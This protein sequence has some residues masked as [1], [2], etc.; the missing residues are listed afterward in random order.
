MKG[1]GFVCSGRLARGGRK[2]ISS[3]NYR[4]RFLSAALCI[5]AFSTG[6]ALSQATPETASQSASDPKVTDKANAYY[7]FAMGHLYAELAGAFGNRS[8]YTNKAIEYYRQAMKLDPSASFLSQELTDL[9]IQAGRI[10]D[11]V[12][13]AE[14]L[15]KQDPDNLD[16]RRLL[17]QIYARLIGDPDQHKVNDEMLQRA[18]EQFQKVTEK[19]PSDIDS[20]L[21]LGR[22]ERVGGNSVEAE[23]DFKKVLDRDP[24]NEEALTELARVYAGVGDN[25][26]A[27]EMLRLVTSKHPSPRTLAELASF[28]HN[29]HDYANAADVWR[30][31]LQMD[32]DNTRL[33]HALADDLLSADRTADA[34][35]LYQDLAAADPRDPQ[36][37][38]RLAEIYRERG[39]FAKAHAALGKARELDPQNLEVRY[40]EVNLLEKE[41]KPDAAIAALRAMLDDTAS[42]NYTEDEKA[43]RTI[44]LERLGMLY[45]DSQHYNEAVEAFRQMAELDPEAAPRASAAIIDTWRTAK[46]L[47]KADAEV[48]AALKKFPKDR[49][50]T[51][52]KAWLLADAGKIDDAVATLRTLLDG[53]KEWGTQITIAQVYE[54]GKRWEDMGKALE[55]AEKVADSSQEK[56]TVA[57]MRGAMLERSKQYDAAEAEF[58]KVLAMDPDNSSA[59]NYLGYMLAD[60]NVRLDEAQKMIGKAVELEPANGAYLDSMGWVCFR[61]N[62]LEEAADYLQKALQLPA[63]AKD[64]TVHDHLGDVYFKQGKIREAI[65]QW[66]SSLKEYEAAVS[67][68][69]AD[70]EEMAQVG[71]KLEDARVRVAKE[72]LVVEKEKRQ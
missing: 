12:S 24:S 63:V 64:P 3:M 55:A 21:T 38:L 28:Y 45:R 57:F 11:A 22:L 25:K 1:K 20:W 51:V 26:N 61:Q 72:D 13:E 52:A 43:R 54:K 30:Q 8:D 37:H 33:K 44:L 9:Y 68:S 47:K 60:R 53:Q 71:K 4:A 49:T 2:K 69:D 62:R 16:A 14:D 18:I 48:Q 65:S 41:G 36:T 10:K 50:L 59:L 17:G 23:K 42:K 15:L 27:I 46:D 67:E 58:R 7:N 6:V 29:S 31:A 40:E 66:Q 32:P 39:D 19:D 34:L 70:P 56:V 35:K 5:A